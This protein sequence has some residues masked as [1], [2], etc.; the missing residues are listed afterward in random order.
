MACLCEHGG[1][2]GFGAQQDVEDGYF[3][4]GFGEVLAQNAAS[5]SEADES[6]ALDGFCGHAIDPA[7]VVGPEEAILHERFWGFNLWRGRRLI[8]HRVIG[9]GISVQL[10]LLSCGPLGQIFGFARE[11]NR[12]EQ[13]DI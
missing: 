11:G 9:L 12:E 3:G 1:A 7:R 2:G 13:E 6:D 10:F 4:A 8:F 5:F